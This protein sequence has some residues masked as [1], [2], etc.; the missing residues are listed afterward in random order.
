MATRIILTQ[1]G[2]VDWMFPERFQGHAQIPLSALGEQQA[3]L[4]G[5]CIARRWKPNVIF[6]SPLSHCVHTG[7]AIEAATSISME[8]LPDLMDMDYGRWQGLTFKEVRAQWPSQLN[9]W[10]H[11][12]DMAEVP[13]GETLADV[14]VRSMHALQHIR[15]KRMGQTSVLVS[16]DSINRVLLMHAL[17]IP[18]SQYWRIKQDP[19]CINELVFDD[20][21]FTIHRINETQHLLG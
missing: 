1:S 8:T 13:G 11:N 12:P 4:L 6:T 9:D 21:T 2:H 18:L 3:Q 15:K 17:G 19:C 10:L 14:L 5:Q 16:H 7:A 20:G